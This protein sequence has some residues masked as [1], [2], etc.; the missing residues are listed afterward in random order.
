MVAPRAVAVSQSSS[1]RAPAP[2]AI[3]KPSRRKS[4]GRDTPTVDSAVMLAK[5][6]VPTGVMAASELPVSTASHRPVAIM[7]AALPT[8]WVPAAQAVTMVSHGPCQP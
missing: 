2:S 7:R 8:E 1:T 6:W 3:T 4:K 5:P